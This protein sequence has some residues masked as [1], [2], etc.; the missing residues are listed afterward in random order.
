[1]GDS[2]VLRDG[3]EMV[4]FYSSFLDR[5]F[6]SIYLVPTIEKLGKAGGGPASPP[7]HGEDGSEAA[8]EAP[9]PK[10][11]RAAGGHSV[12]EIFESSA[13]L[14]GEQVT[15]RGKVVKFSARI[16]GRNWIHLQ[17]GTAGPK[18]AKDLVVT[19]DG[20]AAVG[21]TLLV[22]GTVVTGT[23]LG[24]GYVYDVLIEKASITLE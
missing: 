15:V 10:V 23:D 22:R 16:L 4:G 5:T 1:M 3:F 9:V 2:V 18:G 11:T 8:A 19:T 20:V 14:A 17:D 13:A 21:D 12:G 24:H 7:G 6:D